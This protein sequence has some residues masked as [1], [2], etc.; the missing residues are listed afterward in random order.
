MMRSFLLFFLL[1]IGMIR[2]Q[3]QEEEKKKVKVSP[4]VHFRT[5]WMNTSYPGLDFKEDYALGMS[6]NLGAKVNFNKH[7]AFHVG[8]R[9]FANVWSSDIWE[10]DPLTGQN[11]RYESGL[12]DLLDLRDR[13][14]GRLETFSL[15]YAQDRFGVK[16]GRMGI[17]TDW[18]NAQ[19]GRL[20]PTAVEGIYAWYQP[21]KQWKIGLWGIGGMSIRGS[22]DWLNPGETLGIFPQGRTVSGKPAKYLSNT[23]SKSLVVLELD[24][25]LSRGGNIH[26]S[27][28]WAQNLFSTYWLAFDKKQKLKK[29]T[30]VYGIQ[31]GFQ[32]G[33]GNGGNPDPELRY[34]EPGDLNYALSGRLGWS[35]LRWTTHLNFTKVGGKGRWLSPREWG[36]D[37]WYTFIPRERNEGFGSVQALVAYSEYRLEKVPVQIYAHWGLH[38]LPDLN[39]FQGNKYNSPSYGQWNL[40]VKYQPKKIQN[41]DFHFILMNK[42]ALNSKALTNN[43][44]YNKVEL[45]HFNGIINWRWK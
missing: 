45:I 18:V 4:D 16:I 17:N 14:F 20:A 31:A 13:F 12:F 5:F 21:T 6:L 2:V 7:W 19:D 1:F 36:K 9:A 32:H 34:K 44:I 23:Y 42:Q 25:M 41:L 38:W 24:R 10:A 11:N 8:Y 28:T 37:A 26:L 3:A 30:L 29:E 40:G 22:K 39:D 35:S 27:T 43:Q 15:E 33:L